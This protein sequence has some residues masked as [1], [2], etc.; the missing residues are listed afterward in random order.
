M[1]KGNILLQLSG[2]RKPTCY[3]CNPC[4]EKAGHAVWHA[5][6]RGEALGLGSSACPFDPEATPRSASVIEKHKLGTFG[7]KRPKRHIHLTMRDIMPEHI[8]EGD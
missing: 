6:R 7:T 2:N 5:T 3:R 8:P 4:S 1:R